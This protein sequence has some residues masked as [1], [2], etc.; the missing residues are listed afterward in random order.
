VWEK[1]DDWIGAYGDVD[2]LLS[3]IYLKPDL[4]PEATFTFQ[5]RS[6]WVITA[7]VVSWD[8]V[9]TPV[10]S[11]ENAVEVIYRMDWGITCATTVFDPEPH[12]CYRVYLVGRVIYAPTIG[13]VYLY[14][15]SP[16]AGDPRGWGWG[17]VT[18]ELVGVTAGAL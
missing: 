2:T 8:V 11:F 1:T 18:L 14:E 17:D 4:A 13:P 7:W 15:R 12:G 10:G 5:P 6:G 9:D 16:A 3:W